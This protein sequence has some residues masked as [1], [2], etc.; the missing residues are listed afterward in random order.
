MINLKKT[1][2]VKLKILFLKNNTLKKY[3]LRNVLSYLKDKKDE[4]NS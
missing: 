2:F 1:K 3:N 4:L